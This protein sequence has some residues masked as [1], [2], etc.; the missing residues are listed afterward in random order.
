MARQCVHS[1][2]YKLPLSPTGA[3]ERSNA[4]PFR[5][6]LLC[7]FVRAHN[8]PDEAV[9]D[10]FFT[11]PHSSFHS[12]HLP[13][14]GHHVAPSESYVCLRCRRFSGKVVVEWDDSWPIKCGHW[15]CRLSPIIPAFRALESPTLTSRFITP[16]RGGNASTPSSFPKRV[17]GS[18]NRS[19]LCRFLF[20]PSSTPA[21]D[22]PTPSLSLTL[23]LC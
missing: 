21:S 8:T 14:S 20:S 22:P 7:A 16:L 18:R 17:T 23:S 19:I 12:R 9:P 10:I 13:S 5:R 3:T 11:F 4:H 6:Q 2:H 15:P 1:I